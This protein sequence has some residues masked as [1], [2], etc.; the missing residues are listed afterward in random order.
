MNDSLEIPLVAHIRYPRS[1]P[2]RSS[3]HWTTLLPHLGSQVQCKHRGWRPSRSQAQFFQAAHAGHHILNTVG[4][5]NGKSWSVAAY[6]AD[7]T[8]AKHTTPNQASFRHAIYWLPTRGVAIDQEQ[9]MRNLLRNLDLKTPVAVVG[10]TS[11]LTQEESYHIRSQ[12]K[13]YDVLF[14]TPDLWRASLI[15]ASQ[16]GTEV[17][18]KWTEFLLT[19]SILVLD[20]IDYYDSYTIGHL[21]YLLR[22]ITDTCIHHNLSPPQILACTA[23]IGNPKQFTA[24]FFPDTRGH[25]IVSGPPRRG[26]IDVWVYRLQLVSLD[27]KVHGLHEV[28]LD[29]TLGQNP[30]LIQ[31]GL[32][33]LVY[34]QNKAELERLLQAKNY[35][36]K[37]FDVMHASKETQANRQTHQ[38]FSYGQLQG[39]FATS[40]LDRGLDID[41]LTHVLII[42]FPQ[43]INDCLQRIHRVARNPTQQ[44][45]VYLLLDERH[46]LDR[47]YLEKPQALHRDLEDFRPETLHVNPENPQ[48]VAR[49]VQLALL[50]GYS[51]HDKLTRLFPLDKFPHLTNILENTLLQLRI[52]GYCYTSPEPQNYENHTSLKD[53]AIRNSIRSSSNV[54]EIFTRN[55]NQKEYQVGQ[56]PEEQAIV[57]ACPTNNFFL[58]KKPWLVKDIIRSQII[59]VP[60][61]PLY[62]SRNKVAYR[63]AYKP[64]ATRHLSKVTIQA[65]TA[66]IIHYPEKLREYDV[67][68]PHRSIA[69]REPTQDTRI[70]V[71]RMVTGLLISLQRGKL[72][73]T[74]SL[75]QSFS[76]IGTMLQSAAWHRY[77]IKSN[78]LALLPVEGTATPQILLY[79][80][81]GDTG[82]ILTLWHNLDQLAQDAI[83]LLTTCECGGDG[84]PHCWRRFYP[85]SFIH[86]PKKVRDEIIGVLKEVSQHQWR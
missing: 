53:F 86:P 51:T 21:H 49:T 19:P 79:D 35:W 50:L 73:E 84:C 72:S 57:L 37:G 64:T 8:V 26:P 82:H 5:G 28:L 7:Q 81:G 30:G 27:D 3:R 54:L 48:V 2:R 39:L 63:L 14:C 61:S 59:V 36:L 29:N 17:G 67:N 69:S 24:T 20:E 13:D 80:T 23:T 52:D 58:N 65:V 31:Q 68:N 78:E 77:G 85:A 46:S 62:Q 15:G 55:G 71:D 10:Y 11:D 16:S 6:I 43:S 33:I 1:Q 32:K 45:T 12:C 40:Y 47:Y 70:I 41:S 66:R 56:L 4:T 60:G 75:Q 83:T 25:T 44:G 74:V 18:K 9:K 76:L 22:I 42:G 38:A 34:L